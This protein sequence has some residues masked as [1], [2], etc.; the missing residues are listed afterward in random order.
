MSFGAWFFFLIKGTLP[1]ASWSSMS[2]LVC[3]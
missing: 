3:V 2:R 1:G